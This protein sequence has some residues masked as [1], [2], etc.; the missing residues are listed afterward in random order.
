MST[1]LQNMLYIYPPEHQ[2]WFWAEISRDIRQKK[3]TLQVFSKILNY[4]MVKS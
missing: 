2:N 3:Q 1:M 4:G